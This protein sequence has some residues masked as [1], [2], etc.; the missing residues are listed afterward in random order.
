M[1]PP[2][3]RKKK[4][5]KKQNHREILLSISEVNFLFNIKEDQNP[6]PDEWNFYGSFNQ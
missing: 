6:L 1:I 4:H 3:K 5:K 2:K